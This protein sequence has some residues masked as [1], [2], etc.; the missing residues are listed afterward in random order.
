MRNSELKRVRVKS[1]TELVNW[2][3]GS[4]RFTDAIMLV[5]HANPNSPKHVAREIIVRRVDAYGWTMV[6]SYTLAQS[7]IGH[8]LE[9]VPD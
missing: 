4:A 9:R 6:R 1:E 5:V 7:Q 3:A 8:L 2:L